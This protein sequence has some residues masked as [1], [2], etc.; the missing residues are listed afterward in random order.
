MTASK[1]YIDAD[2]HVRDTDAHYRQYIEAPYNQRTWMITQ[3][4]GD[5]FDRYINGTLGWQHV[6]AHEWLEALDQGGV[7]TTVL[8]PTAGLS[9][10]FLKETDYAVALCR[11]YNNFLSEE[12]LKVSPRLQAVALL[13]LQDVDEAVKELRRAVSELHMVGG[14]LPADGPYLLGKTTWDPLYAE[15]QR[16]DTMVAIHGTGTLLGRGLD[17]YL[18]DRLIQAHSLSH[19][20]SQMRQMASIMFDGVPER[21]PDLR[22]AFLE[23]GCT[24]V[25]YFM[26]RM[27]EEFEFRHVEAPRLTRKPSEYVR[28]SHIFVACEPEERLLP[29]TLRIVGADSILYASD[30]PH[31][32]HS[33]PD[34]LFELEQRE[35]LT[36]E[37]K[38]Q[39][40]IA[41]P[42]RLY[43]LK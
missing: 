20:G 8:Y 6:S 34:S 36:D 5:G 41:N 18:F 21:F 37:D 12:F 23:A 4:G 27:D 38:H 33:F 9:V 1:G 39:I 17:E 42:K 29:E 11:A 7:E 28:D 32:D 31:W 40:L 24:W 2:G 16:L 25:P 19:S 13:P 43:G 30:F 22:I 26:D 3:G 10:G 35:D 14:M 15:A